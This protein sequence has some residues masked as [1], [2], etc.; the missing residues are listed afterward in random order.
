MKMSMVKSIEK[1][2]DAPKGNQLLEVVQDSEGHINIGI[3]GKLEDWPPRL[4]IYMAD[5]LEAYADYLR[6]IAGTKQ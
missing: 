3:A 6:S 4:V 2:L 5:S 1:M